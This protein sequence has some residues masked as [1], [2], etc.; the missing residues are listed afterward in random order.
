MR[1][2]HAWVV[3][4]GL[5]ACQDR[6]VASPPKS[7][8]P[9]ATP[10]LPHGHVAFQSKTGAAVFDV[11]LALDEQSHE[12]GLMFRKEVPDGTG[13]LFVFPS[14]GPRVFWMKNTL[15][16]L[17]MIFLSAARKVVGILENTEPLTTSPRDPHALAQ[18]VLEVAGGTA[19]AKGIH[20]GDL[21]SFDGVP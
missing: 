7:S 16:P 11:E 18:Y 10:A 3:V 21:A 12:R 2:W 13:M 9:P 20:V 14:E 1:P 6:A 19:F 17:D 8:Q 4:A 5:I 15:V